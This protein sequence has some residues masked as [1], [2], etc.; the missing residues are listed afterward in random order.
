MSITI[1]INSLSLLKM[2]HDTIEINNTINLINKDNFYIIL[3][4]FYKVSSMYL[5]SYDCWSV[6]GYFMPRGSIIA[7]I[8]CSYLQLFV[9]LFLYRFFCQWSNQT[10]I[11]FIQI[12]LTYSW[13]SNRYY[14]SSQSGP[15]TNGNED[16]LHTPETSITGA[17][18]SNTI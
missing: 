7:L 15:Q 10:Q 2:L 13:G 14:H 16:V 18:P 9:Q 17:L 1:G 5:V 3:N 11:I 8:V 6:S 12:Y 4:D